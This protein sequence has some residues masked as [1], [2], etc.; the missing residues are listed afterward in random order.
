MTSTTD[1]ETFASR[2]ATVWNEPDPARRSAAI[3]AL[4]DEDGVAFIGS[5]D[6][7][8]RDAIQARVTEAHEQF[9]ATGEFRFVAANDAVHHHNAVTFTVHMVPAAG[10]EPVWAGVVFALLGE[11]GRIHRDYQFAG[12][13]AAT[14]AVVTEF[15][16]RLAEGKPEQIAELFA[17][18]VDWQLDW[19]VEGH[20]AVPWIKPRSTRA[21]VADHFRALNT[22]HVP[23]KS[24]GVAPRI[25]IDGPDAVVLGEI[26]Q[27]V[28]ANGKAYSARC[29]LQLTIDHGL[30]TRYH[31]YED[32]LTVAQALS[33]SDL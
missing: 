27:T 19:P 5:A 24:G 3:A 18:A 14:R 17:E 15:L 9:V 32:S 33:G 11:D 21:E 1:I 22:F 13:Q 4:W 10:G 7:R 6:Y 31:V 23:G 30:I 26:R 25:L 20:P 16:S 8:G 29:A 12:A 2:Y 28:K